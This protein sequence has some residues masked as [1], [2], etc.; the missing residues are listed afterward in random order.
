MINT[1]YD[2]TKD[3]YELTERDIGEYRVIKK[4]GM[5]FDI[6][7]FKVEG[8]GYCSV[9]KMNAMFGL[10]KMDTFVLN[11][12]DK[13][14]PLFSF[15]L[16]SVMGNLTLLVEMYDTRVNKDESYQRILSLKDEYSSLNDH[17]LG[18]HWYDYMKLPTSIAKK[19]KKKMKGN[20]EELAKR[21]YELY[22]GYLK[23]SKDVDPALKQKESDAYVAGLFEN[24]G[25]STDQFVKM[26]GREKAEELFSKYV[27]STRV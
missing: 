26:I 11:P 8:V 27:F 2:L 22:L 13:D 1:I 19:V 21:Y 6:K 20:L 16:I 5:K 4:N 23:E 9:I 10:M 17:D 15:D 12:V 3:S 25:P 14:M 18:T 24:G 7:S